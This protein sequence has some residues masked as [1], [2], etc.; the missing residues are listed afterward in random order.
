MTDPPPRDPFLDELLDG[1]DPEEAG[2]LLEELAMAAAPPPTPALRDRILASAAATHRFADLADRIAR[3]VD[4]D[5]AATDALLLT[6]DDPGRW[7]ESLVPGVSLLHFEGGPRT[8]D[9]IT[10]FIRIDPDASFPV[11]AHLGDEVTLLVQGELRDEATGAIFR[12]GQRVALGAGVEHGP[13]V[14]VSDVP[15]IYLAVVA[16]G[17]TLGGRT[18]GPEDP[19]M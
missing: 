12:R 16:H 14:V 18:F 6:I 4:L 7:A 3:D 15:A 13:L 19:G 11:H 8:A 2:G 5:R 10:G 17:I 1:L 9:A